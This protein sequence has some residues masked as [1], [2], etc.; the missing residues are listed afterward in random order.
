MACEHGPDALVDDVGI[1][2]PVRVALASQQ[3]SQH[4]VSVCAGVSSIGDELADRILKVCLGRFHLAVG[5]CWDSRW[6][7]GG[8]REMGGEPLEQGFELGSDR[9]AEVVDVRLRAE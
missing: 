9:S 2:G 3:S 8:I 1:A 4:V 6:R 7:K 5:R